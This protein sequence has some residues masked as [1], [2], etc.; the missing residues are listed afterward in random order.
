MN[1]LRPRLGPD[2]ESSVEPE[3]HGARWLCACS[4]WTALL[5]AA[6]SHFAIHYTSSPALLLLFFLSCTQIVTATAKPP[7][8]PAPPRGCTLLQFVLLGTGRRQIP[9]WVKH[10]RHIKCIARQRGC[11]P[12]S[13]LDHSSNNNNNNIPSVY[14]PSYPPPPPLQLDATRSRNLSSTISSA[15]TTTTT[16]F[17]D[18]VGILLL[19]LPFPCSIHKIVL[20][21][22]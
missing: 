15:T 14:P 21:P 18:F 1:S 6:F 10:S 3:L 4:P 12:R 13:R 19:R 8:A 16:T 22:D 7:T 11:P 17:A 2:P 9:I 5:P 20:M